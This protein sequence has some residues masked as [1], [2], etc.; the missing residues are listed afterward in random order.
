MVARLS[1]RKTEHL[2]AGYGGT[3]RLIDLTFPGQAHFASSGPS[4]ECCGGCEYWTGTPTRQRAP[5]GKFLQLTSRAG[6]QVPRSAVACKYFLPS[7][8]A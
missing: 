8:R 6:R 3:E 1:I 7:E 4:G 2:T 5:C